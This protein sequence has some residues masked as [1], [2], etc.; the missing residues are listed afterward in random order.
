MIIRTVAEGKTDS[1]IE[2]D[3]KTLIKKYNDLLF[4][5]EKNQ[6]PKLVHNDLKVT[7]SVLRDLISEK[8]EKIVVDSKEDYENIQ[9][10][11]KE[12]ALE[13]GNALEHYRKENRYLKKVESIIQ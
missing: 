11:V 12:D 9:K 3:Y 1:Q 13:I 6:A 8:V 10:M 4:K 5:A 2:N 7:S